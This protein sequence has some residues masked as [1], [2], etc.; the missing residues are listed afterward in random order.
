MFLDIF[1]YFR[2]LFCRPPRRPFLRFFFCAIS[3][4]EGQ[5]T[6]VN[7]GSGRKSEVSLCVLKVELQEALG[8]K[9]TNKALRTVRILLNISACSG[10][11]EVEAASEQ[12]DGRRSVVMKIDEVEEEGALGGR[13]GVCWEGGGVSCLGAKLSRHLTFK[14]FGVFRASGPL[15]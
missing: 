6:P 5:K 11:G 14:Q 7:G 15:R 3:G 9:Q 4:P 13:E 12:A 2:G 8:E 1:G 10:A